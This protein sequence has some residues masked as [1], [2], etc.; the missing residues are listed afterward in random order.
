[1]K[2]FI[3][4]A[5]LLSASPAL[6]QGLS[7]EH[8]WARATAPTAQV[9]G[10]FLTVTATT[11]DRLLSVASPIAGH[12][13]LHR[14]V[15]ENGIMKMLPVEA[16]QVTAG[17]PIEMKPGGLHI[18]LVQLRQPLKTGDTFPLTLTFE[19]AG[20]ITAQV[21]V[22]AAGAAGPALHRHPAPKP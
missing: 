8:P 21:T 3:L 15:E 19:K 2:S 5:A 17:T 14:T 1:M 18:M 7:I 22:E 16:L 13:E 10:A 9:G 6:G 12:A 4:V 11:P 20:P